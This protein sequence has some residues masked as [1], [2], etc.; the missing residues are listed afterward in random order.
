MKKILSIAMGMLMMLTLLPIGAAA[1]TEDVVKIG[2][3]DLERGYYLASVDGSPVAIGAT[4]PTSYVAMYQ[5]GVLTLKNATIST[6]YT[7][8]YP[9]DEPE[10]F[11]IYSANDLTIVLVGNNVIGSQGSFPYCSIRSDG[12]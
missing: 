2:N 10:E 6:W 4:T 11:G 7:T 5:D 9:S 1:Y 12:V 3:T 8:D